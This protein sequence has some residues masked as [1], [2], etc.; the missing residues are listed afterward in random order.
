MSSLTLNL[1]I[2]KA[3]NYELKDLYDSLNNKF[4]FKLIKLILAFF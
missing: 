2:G 4:I 3:F 1:F